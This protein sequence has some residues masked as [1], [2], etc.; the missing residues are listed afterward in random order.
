MPNPKEGLSPWTVDKYRDARGRVPVDDYLKGLLPR[1]H[2]RVLRVIDLLVDYGPMLKMPHARHIEGKIWELRIDGR[3]NSYRVL[4]AGV[5]AR[6]CPWGRSKFLLLH[7][8]AN[9]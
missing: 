1:D 4:Y 9:P 3:P 8:F 6:K 5:P 2:A 7:A